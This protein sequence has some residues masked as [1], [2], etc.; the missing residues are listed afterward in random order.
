[1]NLEEQLKKPLSNQEASFYLNSANLEANIEFIIKNKIESITLISNENGY[2]LKNIEFLKEIPFI[3]ELH[4]GGCTEL[5]NYEGLLYL[6]ELEMLVF[7]PDKRISVDLSNLVNLDYLGFSY[8]SKIYGLDKLINLRTLG[9]G[10]ATDDF[11]KIEIFKNY[12]KLENLKITRSIIG[13]GLSFLKDNTKLESIEFNYMKRAFSI[14]GIQYL[15]DNLKKLNFSSSKKID[16]IHL[17][18]QLVNLESLGFI[19]SVKLE[20]AKILEPLKKLKAFGMYG[21]SSF[22]DGNLTSLK[23]MRDT[24]EH[25]KIQNKKHYFYE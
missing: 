20:N 14:E 22:I 8:S 11:F 13:S 18:S 24:I 12:K 15:K 1:M 16:N 19:E 10:N 23:E 5:Q 17:V 3:K 21:S 4:M 9:I 2:N 6:K 7:T 25:F